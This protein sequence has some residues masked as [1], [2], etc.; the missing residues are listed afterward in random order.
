MF[1]SGGNAHAN[2]FLEANDHSRS[3]GTGSHVNWNR[4]VSPFHPPTRPT[5]PTYL[6]ELERAILFNEYFSTHSDVVNVIR[7]HSSNQHKRICF[8]IIETSK[9]INPVTTKEV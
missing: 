8:S 9:K 4:H 1:E 3:A 2:S 5:N 7:A 6:L